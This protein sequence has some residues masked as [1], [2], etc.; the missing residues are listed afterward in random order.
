MTA[1]ALSV[2]DWTLASGLALVLV[3]LSAIWISGGAA[4]AVPGLAAPAR[5]PR[6]LPAG[7]LPQGST[8]VLVTLCGE[9]A[10]ALS[11]ALTDLRR[12]WTV[13]RLQDKAQIFVLSDTS[14]AEK[15]AAEEAA[16]APLLSAGRVI[17]R[18]RAVN[19]G[20]KPGNIAEWL[21]SHGDRFAYMMVLDADSRMSADRIRAMIHSLETRP[22]TGL[23]QSGMTLVPA[24]SRFG[25]HQRLSARLLSP[26]FGRGMA[27]WS[28]EAGSHWGHNAIM[29]VAA[30]RS[31]ADLPVLS[32]PAPFGG[33]PLS[34]DFVE[35]AWMVRAG[36]AVE[37]DPA[38]AGQRRGR[39]CKPWPS[40]TAAT[41][42]GARAI[43]SISAYWPRPAS[44]R[45]AGC[46]SPRASW[47]IWLR[48]SGWRFWRCLRR[49]RSR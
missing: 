8:A 18:R 9:D 20:R 46:I 36:W 42:A 1:V 23:L 44:I 17:Y 26:N 15:I 16:L 34:H 21:G 30:F 27:A 41:G 2:T 47:A 35:A 24:Q 25:R 48:R 3:T 45:S 40:F 11:A 14:Q 39:A 4:T 38:T 37:L 13:L 22:R 6:A 5:V 10:G 29:R 43:F 33:V 7:W 49:G 32:G 12:G 28:G 19:I 31:A